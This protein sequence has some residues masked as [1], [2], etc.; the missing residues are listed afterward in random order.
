MSKCIFCDIINGVIPS[1]KLFEDENVVCILDIS[2]VTKGHCLI[3]PKQHVNNIIEIKDVDVQLSIFTAMQLV[4]KRLQEKLFVE[5]F[6]I[7]SN[8]GPVAGQVV[9]HAHIHVIPRYFDDDVNFEM[10]PKNTNNIN[11]IYEELKEQ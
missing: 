10:P 1:H 5:N 8:V 9:F 7:L 2:Q 11:L 3:I 6:N 4:T